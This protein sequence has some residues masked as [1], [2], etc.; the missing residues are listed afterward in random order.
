MSPKSIIKEEVGVRIPPPP[1]VGGNLIFSRLSNS[2]EGVLGNLSISLSV[3]TSKNE[4]G[5]CLKS[6]RVVTITQQRGMLP[7]VPTLDVAQ[8][9]THG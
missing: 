2:M 9:P 1:V 4:E 7:I 5:N 3:S 6:Q 8:E